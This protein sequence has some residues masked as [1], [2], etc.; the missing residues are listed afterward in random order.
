[1]PKDSVEFAFMFE[2]VKGTLRNRFFSFVG[3]ERENPLL[4]HINEL[5]KSVG[6]AMVV[7]LP[8]RK[9]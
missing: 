8:A 9:N 5:L 1:M 3:G 6:L 4:Q 2:Q 7:D